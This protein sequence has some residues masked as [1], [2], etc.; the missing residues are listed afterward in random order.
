MKL[1]LVSGYDANSGTGIAQGGKGSGWNSELLYECWIRLSENIFVP[2]LVDLES[3]SLGQMSQSSAA[4]RITCI[5]RSLF[6]QA[7]RSA[8]RKR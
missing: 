3:E 1:V 2:G 6:R 8:H 5:T 7:S 4:G